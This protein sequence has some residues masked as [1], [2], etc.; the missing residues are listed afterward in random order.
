[1]AMAAM[2]A[3]E[4]ATATATAAAAQTLKGH[5]DR[6]WHVA[7]SP[8]GKLLASCGAD[9]SIRVWAKSPKAPGAAGGAAA[10]SPAEDEW[11]CVATLEDTQSRTVRSC[12][13]SPCGSYLAAASFD[14]TV[15]IWQRGHREADD[16]S[17]AIEEWECVS[18]LEGHENE[19]KSVAWSADG[20]MIATCSRDKSIWI[21]E[22]PPATTPQARLPEEDI[23]CECISVLTGHSQ[24]VKHLRWHPTEPVLFTASYDD[25]IRVWAEQVDD[26]GCV[27]VLQGH[28][29]TVWGLCLDSSGTRIASCSQDCSVR[30]WSR[31]DKGT[32][33]CDKVLDE[34]HERTIFSIDWSRDGSRI[35]TG[36]G[37]DAIA[38]LEA[39]SDV[40]GSDFS[41]TRKLLAA[42]DTDV[43]CVRWNPQD[44]HILASA[45]D[46]G[47]VKLFFLP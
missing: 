43:N 17:G 5:D 20:S 46:D 41:V 10:A 26:W 28:T 8:C 22:A 4:A 15:V 19:V 27:E 37:D 35:A 38:V 1:M 7:W 21:W 32:W 12:E 45:G 40:V 2:A 16:G 11:L 31:S 29:N 36:A 6:V 23:E 30:I 42:H 13:F 25:T 33:A 18:V 39:S 14:A 47:F 34:I 24:D 44:S 9:K 3:A